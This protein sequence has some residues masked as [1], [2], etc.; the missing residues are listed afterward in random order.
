M[1]AP[2]TGIEQLSGLRAHFSTR[3]AT[4]DD[5]LFLRMLWTLNALQSGRAEV[6]RRFLD[7]YPPD[8]ATEGILGPHAI[9]PWEL[10]TLANE[11]LTTP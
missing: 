10:E 9:Y 4:A 1:E 11:L 8:A 2:P 6:A 3:L 7:D 5:V